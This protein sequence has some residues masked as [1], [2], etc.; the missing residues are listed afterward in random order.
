VALG[1]A[2][3]LRTRFAQGFSCEIKLTAVSQQ[4]VQTAEQS[5][6]G[7]L[8][9]DAASRGVS[10]GGITQVAAAL[11]NRSRDDEVSENGSGW[12]LHAALNAAAGATISLRDLAVWWAEEDQVATLA[13]YMLTAFPGAILVERHG[14]NVRFRLPPAPVPIS[15]LFARV[16]G[17]R[18]S[19]GI[20]SYTL[21]QQ[22][23]EQIFNSFAAGQ[24]EEK[25]V[26]RGM[27]EVQQQRTTAPSASGSVNSSASVSASSSASPSGSRKDRVAVIRN[28]L[29]ANGSG[30]RE[31]YESVADGSGAASDTVPEWSRANFVPTRSG[32]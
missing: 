31:G 15:T 24:E 28:P 12:A 26:A 5:I 1:T 14:S 10:R 32:K 8:G 27:L 2:Q 25:G 16:E 22:T 7:V 29:A 20:A 21:G 13:G 6:K 4:A 11:N 18:D 30:E 9:G 3:H 19:C 17:G 23:L